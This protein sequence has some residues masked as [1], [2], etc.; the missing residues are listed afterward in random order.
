MMAVVAVV[1]LP[2]QAGAQRIFGKVVLAD[3]RT[4]AAGTI[5]TA[6]D[7]AGATVA[8]ELTTA[9]GDYIMPLSKPGVLTLTAT[10][11]GSLPEVVRDVNVAEGRDLR[12]GITLSKQVARLAPVTTR[13][14]ESCAIA[15]ERSDAATLWDQLQ[16]ALATTA[17]AE[18]AR[19]F[20]AT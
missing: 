11:I 18:Q 10:R 4:A 16:I 5:V 14:G 15:S 1:A 17:L 3:G 2:P 8:R 7:A 20:V 12:V 9:R 6:T 19:I 13:S